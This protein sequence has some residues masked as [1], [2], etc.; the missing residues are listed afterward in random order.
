MT[1]REC[2][3]KRPR[4]SVCNNFSP[5]VQ[6]DEVHS[7]TTDTDKG[8]NHFVVTITLSANSH[9]ELKGAEPAYLAILGV[10]L[11]Q[12]R[13]RRLRPAYRLAAIRP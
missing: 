5:Q 4:P 11:D 12:K 8:G 13:H 2:Q 9:S 1:N 10:Y 3:T 7:V 6:G